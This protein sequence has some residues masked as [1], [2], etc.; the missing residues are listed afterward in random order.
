MFRSIS[1]TSTVYR[2]LEP[3]LK[4][5]IL[6]HVG[7]F[8]TAQSV[9]AEELVTK[10]FYEGS[11]VELIYLDFSKAFDLVKLSGHGIASTVTN[12]VESFLSPRTFQ[13]NVNEALSQ[14]TEAVKSVL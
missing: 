12:R 14:M 11:A 13:G 1:F 8:S 10:W 6:T 2:V 7:V 9:E 5:K 3:T 4:E